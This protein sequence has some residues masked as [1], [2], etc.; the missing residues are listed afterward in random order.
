MAR[1]GR[2]ASNSEPVG[3]VILNPPVYGLAISA[4]IIGTGGEAASAGWQENVVEALEVMLEGQ[5]GSRGRVDGRGRSVHDDRRHCINIVLLLHFVGDLG[6]VHRGLRT[7]DLLEHRR[8][9][10][11]A[12][13]VDAGEPSLGR[14]V[15]QSTDPVQLSL[16]ES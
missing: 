12:S 4:R 9:L 8:A 6:L 2:S 13:R 5:I 3:R 11:F 7:V 10:G 14:E 15:R 16:R 1:C